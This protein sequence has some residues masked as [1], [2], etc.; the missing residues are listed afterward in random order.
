MGIDR[1]YIDYL[2]KYY[3]SDVAPFEEGYDGTVEYETLLS[4]ILSHQHAPEGYPYFIYQE[5]FKILYH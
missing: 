5:L 4:K 2:K 3:P 1:V